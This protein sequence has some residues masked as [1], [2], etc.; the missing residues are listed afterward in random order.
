MF[1][2]IISHVGEIA[3]VREIP[4]GRELVVA[5]ALPLAAI[6]LGASV[7]HAGICLTVDPGL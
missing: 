4:G 1:T 5:S 3:A 2:G 7:A 6:D